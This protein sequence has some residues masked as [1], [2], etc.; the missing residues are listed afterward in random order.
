MTWTRDG[1]I[2]CSDQHK[3]HVKAPQLSI[4]LTSLEFEFTCKRFHLKCSL[5]LKLVPSKSCDC[6]YQSAVAEHSLSAVCWPLLPQ[7]LPEER[8]EAVWLRLAAVNQG[9][10]QKASDEW[11]YPDPG[12]EAN[13]SCSRSLIR[14]SGSMTLSIQ[15]QLETI[16][17]CSGFLDRPLR[18]QETGKLAAQ[19]DPGNAFRGQSS[20]FYC[21]WCRENYM[22][23][24]RNQERLFPSGGAKLCLILVLLCV[25]RRVGRKGKGY[26]TSN[27]LVTLTVRDTL[28]CLRCSDTT[29]RLQKWTG[30]KGNARK[31]WLMHH[32]FRG[33]CRKILSATKLHMWKGRQWIRQ[34][35]INTFMRILGSSSFALAMLIQD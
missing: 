2:K 7:S 5:C 6:P 25:A 13:L 24:R 1:R 16:F 31:E 23:C 9:T 32:R 21:Q 30:T 12:K 17:S 14:R 3:K 18:M 26:V 11:K 20:T 15:R 28:F 19:R 29:T 34:E 27:V 10:K 8:K 33:T 4:S 35:L 22:S